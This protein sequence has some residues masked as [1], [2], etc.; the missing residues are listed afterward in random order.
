MESWA[1]KDYNKAGYELKAAAHGL[2]SAAGWVGGEAKAGASA[3]VADTRK[4][5]DKLTS[6]LTWTRDEVAKGL[7]T[8]G[9]SL[10]ELGHKIDVTHQ[11]TR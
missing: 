11:E 9:N 3:M 8:L 6:G 5:G 1:R 4:L 2:E 10:I 7:E